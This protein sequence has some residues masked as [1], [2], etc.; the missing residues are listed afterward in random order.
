MPNISA[1]RKK[2]VDLS[3]IRSPRCSLTSLILALTVV[4]NSAVEE[5]LETS[6]QSHFPCRSVLQRSCGG[7]VHGYTRDIVSTFHARVFA[8]L[9]LVCPSADL[10]EASK[11]ISTRGTP[12]L[13]CT[14]LLSLSLWYLLYTI[15]RTLLKI[16]PTTLPTT[17]PDSATCRCIRGIN[18]ERPGN[19]RLLCLP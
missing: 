7:N 11:L 5:S 8:C 17:W 3:S 1:L 19:R 10:P 18:K 2:P 16:A 13:T 14:A 12:Y 15:I 6:N 9:T 4:A